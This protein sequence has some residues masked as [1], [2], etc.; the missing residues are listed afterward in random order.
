MHRCTER[1]IRFRD[2]LAFENALADAHHGLGVIADVLRYRQHELRWNRNLVNGLACGLGF[3]AFEAQSAMQLA[4]IISGST[5][6]IL[7]KLMQSTGQ[8]AMQSS[9]PVHSA[10]ITVCIN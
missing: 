9:Q 8:G 2:Q 3:V 5:H 4:K 1:A 10:A 7:R 6:A